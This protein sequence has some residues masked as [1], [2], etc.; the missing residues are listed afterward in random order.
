M[1]KESRIAQS[2]Y[3]PQTVHH[4]RSCCLSVIPAPRS[5]SS[6]ISPF[7][8]PLVSGSGNDQRV[9]DYTACASRT[10]L[11]S[12]CN[13][14][15]TFSIV[16]LTLSSL[17]WSEQAGMIKESWITQSVRHGQTCYLHVIL[18]PRPL[19]SI[20]TSFL[21]PPPGLRRLE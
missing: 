16:L 12:S 2:L 19:S 8:P 18:A 14:C 13:T 3:V 5:L 17:P 21:S 10:D 1:I 6:F 7:L 11:S 20:L 15:S 4:V 9:M